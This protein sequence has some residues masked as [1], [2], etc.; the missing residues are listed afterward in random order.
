MLNKYFFIINPGSNHHKSRKSIEIL[1]K[2]LNSKN[3]DYDYKETTSL[4]DAFLF[5]RD[6]N[7]KGYE[8]I[9]AVGGDGTINK[10]L[11]G[12]YDETGKRISS[13]KLGVIHTGT[14]PDF[15]K[16][17]AIPVKST[18][19][20][21]VLMQNTAKE[22]SIARI[23]FY[24]EKRE[25]MIRYFA[26]CASVGLGSEVAKYA[27]SGIRKYL[28]DSV[29]TFLSIIKS[30]ASYEASDLKLICDEK[31]FVIEKNFNTFIGK[32]SYIASGMKVKNQ[33]AVNDNRLY[34]LSLKKINVSNIF[35]A[36][37]AIYSGKPICNQDYISFDYAESIEIC[38]TRKKVGI[39]F[40]GDAQGYLPCKI[41]I[42]KEKLELISNGF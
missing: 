10:V 13:A 20:L 2:E 37:R 32:T 21:E 31:E 25:K 36:L 40:D 39:E 8:I 24:N 30:L 33:L 11:S 38:S 23:E 12:F 9:V 27:N 17:Y 5:S 19:A 6:A 15:C 1:K 4:E 26:C 18:L 16:S 28:G 41:S 22:I 42:A 3:I 35:P 34:L 29:G 7:Q 14:S